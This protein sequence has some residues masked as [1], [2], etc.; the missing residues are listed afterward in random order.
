MLDP[1][2]YVAVADRLRD[3]ASSSNLP[4]EA[5]L[6]VATGRYDY[7]ALLSAR[8]YLATSEPIPVDQ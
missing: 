7:A 5:A 2:E 6:R 1:V 8:D 3:L 4:E